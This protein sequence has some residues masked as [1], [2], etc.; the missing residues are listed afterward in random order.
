MAYW[1]SI[2][3]RGTVGQIPKF[4]Q[5]TYRFMMKNRF[6]HVYKDVHHHESTTTVKFETF[7]NDAGQIESSKH[8]D[9]IEGEIV[10]DEERDD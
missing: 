6:P 9:A 10:R 5:A 8:D 3:E 1:E 2:G 4:Q 7:V